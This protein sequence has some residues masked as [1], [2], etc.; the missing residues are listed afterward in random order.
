M[1]EIELSGD[2]IIGMND[3][4]PLHSPAA[5]EGYFEG[6]L[7]GE[8]EEIVSVPVISIDLVIPYLKSFGQRFSAYEAELERF[9]EGHPE[10]KCIML[11]G[12]HRSAGAILAHKKIPCFWIE[13]DE[14]I[15]EV[16]NLM[17]SGKLSGF[18]GP[19]RTIENTLLILENHFFS[20]K[21]FWT[22]KEKVDAMIEHGD[23]PEYM[24][25]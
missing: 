10:V 9:I 5:L 19:E 6:F 23:V 2:E 15:K 25:P 21:C 22:A 11:D 24:L 3:Y 4:P 16:K 13:K 17:D 1:K 18:A 12:K 7:K 14:D 8:T 20:T